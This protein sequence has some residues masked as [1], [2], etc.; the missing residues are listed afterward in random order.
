MNLV[1][2]HF[3]S[4]PWNNLNKY[5]LDS[6]VPGEKKEYIVSC[7]SWNALCPIV[8]VIMFLQGQCKHNVQVT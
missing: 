6:E 2:A 7:F 8:A 5:S 3:L 4:H 1:E